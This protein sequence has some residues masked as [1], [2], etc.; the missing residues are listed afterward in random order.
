[1]TITERKEDSILWLITMWCINWFQCSKSW[2][3]RMRRLQW[4]RNGKSGRKSLSGRW[5]RRRDVIMK[6]QKRKGKSTP[7]HW[8]TSVISRMPSWNQCFKNTKAGLCSEVTWWRDGSGSDAVFTEQGPSASQRLQKSWILKTQHWRV[9]PKIY[10]WVLFWDAWLPTTSHGSFT[11]NLPLPYRSLVTRTRE[12]WCDALVDSCHVSPF[13]F[14]FQ[15]QH[16][17]VTSTHCVAHVP[18]WLN[19]S[20]VCTSLWCNRCYCEMTRMRWTSRQRS[21]CLHPS[22]M[23][24]APRLLNIPKSECPDSWIRLPRHK[25]PKSWSKTDGPAVPLERH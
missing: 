25:W 12:L 20:S 9:L 17:V 5:I 22:K 18:E 8:W 23:E 14:H 16:R 1:M 6:A 15:Q 10:H 7:L 24:D 19:P 13:L 2:N 21:I 11:V 3:F 4:I